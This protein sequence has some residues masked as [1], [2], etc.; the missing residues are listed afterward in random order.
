MI[1]KKCGAGPAPARAAASSGL[2]GPGNP[3]AG[4]SAGRG[5]GLRRLRLASVPFL[6][7]LAGFG[8]DAAAQSECPGGA[9]VTVT[10]SVLGSRTMIDEGDDAYFRMRTSGPKRIHV[11]YEWKLEGTDRV[12][13]GAITFSGE[14]DLSTIIPFLLIPESLTQKELSGFKGL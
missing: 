9:P 2:S 7:L 1:R 5:S 8:A 3:E 10:V 14:G 4:K 11:G 6:F 13:Y 12:Q